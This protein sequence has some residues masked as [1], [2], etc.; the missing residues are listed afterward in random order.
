MVG[1]RTDS[2]DLAPAR[3]FHPLARHRDELR[4][5]RARRRNRR[6]DGMADERPRLSQCRE[7]MHGGRVGLAEIDHLERGD[8][9]ASA[10]ADHL[11]Q[12][13]VRSMRV[14]G[15]VGQ[16][17]ARPSTIRLL[18]GTSAP[19]AQCSRAIG[20][21]PHRIRHVAIDPQRPSP[22]P[23][24][25]P[26]PSSAR[27][28]P[29]GRADGSGRA[30]LGREQARIDPGAGEPCRPAVVGCGVVDQ[31]R[32]RPATLNQPCRSISPSSCPAPQPA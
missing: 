29:A 3:Q 24:L 20:R 12:P 26:S 1:M 14:P 10:L 8:A 17:R 22:L 13:A 21:P 31:R 7:L 5:R 16:A 15:G 11:H 27:S 9:R 19:S 23:P 32:R 30:G 6:A 25:P 4:H 2:A 28:K 18:A